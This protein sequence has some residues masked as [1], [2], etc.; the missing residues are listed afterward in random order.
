MCSKQFPALITDWRAGTPPCKIDT[1]RVY[2]RYLTGRGARVFRREKFSQ[3]DL[4][5]YF[6]QLA[7]YG[8]H[9][10]THLRQAQLAA[11]ALPITGMASAIDLGE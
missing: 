6:V 7:A 9:D 10:Y 2:M 3:P 5:F 1:N 11:L 8:W 4:G